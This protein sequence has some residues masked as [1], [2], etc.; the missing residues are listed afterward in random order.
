MVLEAYQRE[1][2]EEREETC[3]GMTLS[4]TCRAAGTKTFSFL[5]MCR[6]MRR[7]ANSTHNCENQ[8]IEQEGVEV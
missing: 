6:E 7:D 2:G 3:R 8:C 4:L 1:I 5:L